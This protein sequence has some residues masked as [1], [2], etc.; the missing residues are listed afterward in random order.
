MRKLGINCS[1]SDV[2]D[3]FKNTKTKSANSQKLVSGM[4]ELFYYIIYNVQIKV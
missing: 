1:F 4:K 3:N 2:K